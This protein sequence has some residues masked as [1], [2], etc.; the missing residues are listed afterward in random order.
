MK[1]SRSKIECKTKS[2]PWLKI[3]GGMVEV[4]DSEV[5][6]VH[7]SGLTNEVKV[8]EKTALVWRSSW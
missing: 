4:D 3:G 2:V 5:V 1:L 8:V 6:L 7:W